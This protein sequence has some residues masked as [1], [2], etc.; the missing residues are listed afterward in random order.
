MDSTIIVERHDGVLCIQMN[1][2]EK[3]NALTQAMYRQL[4]EALE[5]LNN[6]SGLFVGVISGSSHNFTSGND[7]KDF[8]QCESPDDLAD[9]TNFLGHLA[10]ISK[11]MIA[12][13]EGVAVGIGTTMLAYCDLVYASKDVRFQTPFVPLGLSP[14]A[15]SSLLFPKLMGYQRAAEC[16]LLGEPFS[17][18]KA[19]E[20]GLVNK[21][22]DSDIYEFAMSQARKLESLPHQA[23]L[24]AK[25]LLRHS[26]ANELSQTIQRENLALF[27]LL[28]SEQT[29]SVLASTFKKIKN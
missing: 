4:N 7:L 17:S 11:P 5:L 12:A 9:V 19:Y 21:I 22:L 20:M 15:G 29:K 10:Q 14:E 18:E 1:R 27:E 16:L 13:V 3:K 25:Q 23:L 28:E 26:Y 2:P 24:T 8:I 6:D